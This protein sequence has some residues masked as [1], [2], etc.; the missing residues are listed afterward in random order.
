MEWALA[1]ITV[2]L[3]SPIDLQGWDNLFHAKG[4]AGAARLKLPPIYEGIGPMIIP[5]GDTSFSSAH[6]GIG[7]YRD[8]KCDTK[9]VHF[10]QAVGSL[11]WKTQWTV[12][13]GEGVLSNGKPRVTYEVPSKEVSDIKSI[14]TEWHFNVHGTKPKATVGYDLWLTS[15]GAA[16]P[17]IKVQV[18]LAQLGFG[19]TTEATRFGVKQ[20]DMVIDEVLYHHWN[21]AHSEFFGQAH[22]STYTYVA[23]NTLDQVNTDLL[24]F[25]EPLVKSGTIPAKAKLTKIEAGVDIYYGTA[26]F[27]TSSYKISV[28]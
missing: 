8:H 28:V 14:K 12:E 13:T 23:H 9:V 21:Q 20:S 16:S 22:Y 5:C 15:P 7:L 26:T 24:K 27:E 11:A 18:M 3:A 1:F 2:T 25:L 19:A 4:E 6:F 17:D 10:D